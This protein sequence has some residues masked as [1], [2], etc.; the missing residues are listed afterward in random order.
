MSL[1]SL[2]ASDVRGQPR[3]IL[4]FVLYII[5]IYWTFHSIKFNFIV[6]DTSRI[7]PRY[8]K[9]KFKFNYHRTAAYVTG[10]LKKRPEPRA[11]QL[12]L[13]HTVLQ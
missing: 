6:V 13:R 3:I 10:E 2:D 4:H 8:R 7:Y 5:A 11:A 1:S 12:N 9:I